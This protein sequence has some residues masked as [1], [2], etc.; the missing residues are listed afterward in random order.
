MDCRF[1]EPES[2]LQAIR[3]RLRVAAEGGARLV[4]FPECAL[5]GY[6][7]ESKE[8]AWSHAEP[9]HGP[10]MNMVAADCRSFGVWA[11]VG[12]LERDDASGQFFNAAALIGP[13]GIIGSYRKI[14]LPCLG[15]DRFAAPGDRPFEVHD[16]DGLRI[17]INI[18]YDGSFPESS[19]VLTLLGADL[20]VLPTN[21][22][23][24]ARSTVKHLVQARAL[25]NHIYYLAVNRIGEER[26]FQFLGQS[27]IVN[28]DGELL[29][30]SEGRSDEI[31]YAE[32]DPVAARQKQVVNI[33]QKYEINRVD[34][35]RPEMYGPLCA[36]PG[37]VAQR[38]TVLHSRP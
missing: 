17:G 33:P 21:W 18:C 8:E 31:L 37:R 16:L 14:H 10:S 29:A 27:R 4:T 25:E 12:F 38:N 5:T 30:S 24:G 22:P 2:N 7:F 9:L 32:L 11:I 1:G 6:C 36:T 34:H 13:A 15:V 3:E 26:G 28:F 19:R 20:V 35:R 23:T